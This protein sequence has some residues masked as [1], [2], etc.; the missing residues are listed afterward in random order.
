MKKLLLILFISLN[1]FAIDTLSLAQVSSSTDRY[2]RQWTDTLTWNRTANDTLLIL[3][4]LIANDD[5]SSV[6]F[7]ISR[8]DWWG[9]LGEYG[10]ENTTLYY[11]TAN[12]EAD[13]DSLTT[14][15]T[16]KAVGASSD[17]PDIQE[18]L[19]LV[20]SKLIRFMAIATGSTN[21]LLELD[22]LWIRD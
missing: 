20:P 12:A 4:E 17:N 10:W 18:S 13:F 8:Y 5:T 19:S 7:P 2:I 3:A 11:Q 16:L 1:V 6:S 9:V 14:W 22:L 21:A 15:T